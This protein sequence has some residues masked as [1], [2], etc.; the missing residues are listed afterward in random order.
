MI[1]TEKPSQKTVKQELF[2]LCL[3]FPLATE[4]IIREKTILKMLYEKTKKTYACV[5]KIFVCFTDPS[6]ETVPFETSNPKSFN[7][8]ICLGMNRKKSIIYNTY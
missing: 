5:I 7:A 6:V 1:M 2:F 3:M 4:N 8:F